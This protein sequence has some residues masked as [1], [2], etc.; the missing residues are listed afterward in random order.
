MNKCAWSKVIKDFQG[1]SAFGRQQKCQRHEI[2][3]GFSSTKAMSE[4]RWYLLLSTNKL[5]YYNFITVL[6]FNK[7][8]INLIAY[9]IK[10]LSKLR[11]VL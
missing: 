6:V 9:F 2:I 7:K 11:K 3:I 10:N 5:F 8:S 4:R 1:F